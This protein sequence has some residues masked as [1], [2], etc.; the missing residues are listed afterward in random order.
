MKR[1]T[2][3]LIGALSVMAFAVVPSMASA[4]QGTIVAVTHTQQHPDTTSVSGTGTIDSP[5]GP[6]WAY[7]NLSLRFVVTP[8][9]GTDP[10]IPGSFP[11][12][13]YN[14]Q[15]RI[16]AQGSFAG[17]ANPSTGLPQVNNGSVKGTLEYDV[18]SSTPPDPASLP[19]QQPSGDIGQG[20]MLNELFNGN[21]TIVGGGHYDYRYNQVDGAVYTQVG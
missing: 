14:Y 10:A 6:V 9:S 8:A 5:G 21:A 20:A 1:L 13:L 17:F 7:D 19:A 12:G 3:L 11:G 2:L 18:Y 4:S 16:E 15:V